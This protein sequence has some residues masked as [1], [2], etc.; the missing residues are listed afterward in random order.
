MNRNEAIELIRLRTGQDHVAGWD[1]RIR[2]ELEMAQTSLE[3]SAVLPWF[4]INVD[5]T[6]SVTAGTATLTLPTGFLRLGPQGGLYRHDDTRDDP[7]VGLQ[8]DTYETLSARNLGSGTVAYYALLGNTVHLFPTPAS[9]TG[10]R[11][12]H[13]K[14]G[15]SLA[16]NTATNPWL[17]HAPEVLL[18]EAAARIDPARTGLWL[19]LAEKEKTRIGM[20]DDQRHFD[21]INPRIIPE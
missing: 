13:F 16:T 9:T 6:L 2:L 10:F 20:H 14:S 3:W 15:G 21:A 19:E 11:L 4:L 17:V 12:I 7:W 18:H 5:D 8:R 1:E